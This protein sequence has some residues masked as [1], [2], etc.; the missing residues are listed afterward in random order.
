MFRAI[1]SFTLGLVGGYLAT[2]AWWG[3]NLTEH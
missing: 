1:A 2:R 3:A